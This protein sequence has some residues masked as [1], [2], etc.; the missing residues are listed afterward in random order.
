[1]RQQIICKPIGWSDAE[2][3]STAALA[4]HVGIAEPK[5]LI[6]AFF[7]EIDLGA[8][9][10]LETGFINHDLDTA[11]LEYDIAVL[12]FVGIVDDIGKAVAAGFLNADAEAD[13]PAPGIEMGPDPLRG[14]FSQ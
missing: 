13:A 2:T 10:E 4:G 6:E 1:M 5:R 11:L 7:H 14:R 8:I 3:L 12:D 9:D